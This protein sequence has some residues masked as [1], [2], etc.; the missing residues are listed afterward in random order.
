MCTSFPVGETA[1][2]L[3]RGSSAWSKDDPHAGQTDCN[4]AADGRWIGDAKPGDNPKGPI[5]SINLTQGQ[6]EDEEWHLR[7]QSL[8]AERFQLRI[9]K[10]TRE[11]Q[12]Y[13]PVVAKN[14]PKFKESKFDE[15]ALEKALT[16]GLKMF[17]YRLSGTSADIHL[18]TESC[19][20]G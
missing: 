6:K 3:T 11:A 4:R 12:V 2:I 13:S 20:G 16:P 14:G 17:E 15:S 19:H 9:H 1:K 7:I 8:R 5:L 18:L 10:Q